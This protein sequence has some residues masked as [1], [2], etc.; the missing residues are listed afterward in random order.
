MRPLRLALAP[1]LAVA[2]LAPG[3][4]AAAFEGEMQDRAD[5]V[6]SRDGSRVES[7]STDIRRFVS[8]VANGRVEQRVTMAGP[9]SV[10]DDSIIVRSWFRHSVNGTFYVVDLEVHGNAVGRDVFRAYTRRD[11][12][13]NTSPID[14]TYGIDGND[15]VFSFRVAQIP[16]AECFLPMVY[17][18][19]PRAG[20][21][22]FDSLGMS[23]RPCATSPEPAGASFPNMVAGIPDAKTGQDAPPTVEPPGTRTPSPA[24]TTALGLA[25][26]A[27]AVGFFRPWKRR[28]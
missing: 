1:A 21:D 27:L 2:L 13:T 24:L 28:R 9:P 12:F 22:P 23:G 26:V 6:V 20:S 18:Y 16:D 11:D 8:T 5:D 17:A 10:P 15:W 14:A 25:G 4:L 7:P 19:V 3:A